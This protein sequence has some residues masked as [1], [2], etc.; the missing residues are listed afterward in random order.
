MKRAARYDRPDAGEYGPFHAGYVALVPQG[1]VLELLERQLEE[2]SALL[3]GVPES[4]GDFAYAPGKWTIKEV[5][6]HLSDAERVFAYRALRF[7]R[8][9]A[10]PLPGFDEQRWTPNSGASQR[11]LADLLEEFQAV[12]AATL[13]LFRGLPPEAPTRHGVASEK[14]TSVRALVWIIAGHER[15]HLKILRERYLLGS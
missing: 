14:E 10:T 3:Q 5:L 7:A 9:D 2:S 15:H 13:A 4:R 12:R 6:C 11:T 8:G 1:D